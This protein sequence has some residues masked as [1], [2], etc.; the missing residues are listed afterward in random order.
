MNTL[1][2]NITDNL[3]ELKVKLGYPDSDV[4]LNYPA[5]SLKSLLGKRG[6][7]DGELDSAL[8]R[9]FE[10]NAASLQDCSFRRGKEHYIITLSMKAARSLL[11]TAP[12]N[13]LVTEL[14]RL[15]TSGNAAR[16]EVHK[17]FLAHSESTRFIPSKTGDFD[18]LIYTDSED[19]SYFYLFHYGHG[20]TEYHRLLPDDYREI[21]E[22]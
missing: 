6:M 4:R 17:L 3:T 19:D 2:Q 12:E 21:Y 11:D 8:T 10:E 9:F 14:C 22:K 18:E 5:Q 7:T 13:S 1:I 16:D 20:H 15:V